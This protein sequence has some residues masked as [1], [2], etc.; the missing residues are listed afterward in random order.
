M[1]SQYALAPVRAKLIQ[2]L[3]IG[4][5]WVSTLVLMLILLAALVLRFHDLGKSTIGH[6]EVYVPGIEL[7]PP[8]LS[9]PAPRL[10]LL[11]AI[12][13]P[14][15]DEPHPPAYYVF[16]YFWTQLFGTGVWALRLPSALLGIGSIV[17]LYMLG[18]QSENRATALVGAGMLAFHGYHLLWSQLAK[19]Y[20]MG[21][22]LGLL[23]TVL[24]LA[25]RRHGRYQLILQILYVAITWTGL[26][27]VLFFWPLFLVQILWVFWRELREQQAWG[28]VLR[29][30][31]LTFI[32]GSPLLAI[33][34][35]Q[36]LRS[37]YLGGTPFAHVANFLQFGFLLEPFLFSSD[38][39]A[40]EEV[41][42][43]TA[44]YAALGASL[45]GILV[46]IATGL[47]V[48][49]WRAEK[50]VAHETPSIRLPQWLLMTT[51]FLI[52][53]GIVVLAFVLRMSAPSPTKRVLALSIVPLGLGIGDLLLA[54]YWPQV[55]RVARPFLG[56]LDPF[57]GRN[58][59]TLLALLPA[60]AML[61]LWPITQIFAPRTALLYIPYLLLVVARGLVCLVQRDK[62]WLTLG[63]VVALAFGVSTMHFKQRLRHPTDYSGLA[64]QWIGQIAP[65]D[66]IFVKRH[67]VTTPI[68]YYLDFDRYHFVGY[69]YGE[70]TR[71]FPVARVWVLSF[72][73]IPS[74][75][76]M[77]EALAGY[78]RSARLEALRISAELYTR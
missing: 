67:W 60:I 37:S 42:W 62:R 69:D 70:M 50:G 61:A 55:R 2:S 32:L 1:S 44:R 57:L 8:D 29:L 5:A 59:S 4:K 56:R 28:G 65:S 6:I 17:L 40:F 53:L 9:E 43:L 64:Q 18:V 3:P 27:T 12:A 49:A 30:Q 63:L 51:A 48:V 38:P 71:A 78:A 11:A 13:D 76:A 72:Q 22:F 34:A 21:C 31:L 45:I 73:G 77:D 23:S 15:L 66:L 16:M 41:S 68:F 75:K 19:M 52:S 46:V 20:M 14:I 33:A 7:A 36:S 47:V 24:L 35:H 26:A 74:S 25:L 39:F 58:L 10:T 54:R